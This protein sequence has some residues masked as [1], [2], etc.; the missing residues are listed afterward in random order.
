MIIFLLTQTQFKVMMEETIQRALNRQTGE[1]QVREGWRI[2][3]RYRGESR[4]LVN[5][6]GNMWI[7]T[8]ATSIMYLRRRGTR[9]CQK[10]R[11]CSTL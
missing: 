8:K 4:G 1:E 5:L 6:L 9:N 10:G 11:K 2:Q 3:A 7:W